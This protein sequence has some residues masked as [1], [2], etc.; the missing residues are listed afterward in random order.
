MKEATKLFGGNKKLAISLHARINAIE[1]ADIIRDIILTPQFRFHNLRGNLEGLFAIDVK[2][3][4][5]KWRIILCPLDGNGEAYNPC[6]IDEISGIVN[7]V[8]IEEVSPHYE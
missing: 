1:N 4:R 7:I 2:S 8:R 5:D 3:S 6:H